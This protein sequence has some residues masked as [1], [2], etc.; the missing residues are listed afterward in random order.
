MMKIFVSQIYIKA[1]IRFPFSCKFQI[2]MGEVLTIL[3]KP[4][5]FF[6]ETY[7]PDYK[8]MFNMSAK[9]GTSSCDV[10]GP[11]VY[12]KEEDVEYSIF[13]PYDEIMSRED[14][15]RSALKF[16]LEGVCQVF[17]MLKIDLAN[18]AEQSPSI[19]ESICSNPAM[20]EAR[21]WDED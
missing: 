9:E 12:R 14:V 19:I 7:G 5:S 13:L 3:T 1:G 2:E 10:K 4:S 15:L 18:I 16:F 6:L 21:H 20:L 17:D 11:T 8:L